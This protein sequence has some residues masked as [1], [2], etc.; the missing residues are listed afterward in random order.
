L[1]STRSKDPTTRNREDVEFPFGCREVFKAS[2]RNF[3]NGFPVV[4]TIVG[5]RW[6]FDL[7]AMLTQILLF[8]ALAGLAFGQTPEKLPSFDAADVHASPKSPNPNVQSLGGFARGGRYQF[9]N[10]TMVD[11]ISSAYGVEPE[12]VLGGPSWLETDRFDILAKAPTSVTPAT[13]KLMLRSLLAD[14]FKLAFHNEDKPMNGWVMTAAKPGPQLKQ[15]QGAGPTNCNGQP[16]DGPNS[17]IVCKNATMAVV[18]Q[19]V[20]QIEPAT[21]DTPVTD[22]TA[23]EGSF[24]FQLTWTNR[25]ALATAGKDAI[26]I[27]EAL[28]KQLGI[29]LELQKRAVATLVVDSVNRKPTDNLPG[30]EKLVPVVPTEFEVAEM[31]PSGPNTPVR[32]GLQPGGR[33]DLQGFTLKQLMLVSLGLVGPNNSGAGNAA[34]L[35]SGP[36]FL[37]SDHYDIVAKAPADVALSGTD[38]DAETLLAMLRTMLIDRFK[39][40]YHIEDQPINVYALTFQKRDSRLKQADPNSRSSCKR[41]VANNASGLPTATLTCQNTTLAQLAEKLPAM[42]PAYVDHP[43]VDVSGLDGGWDFALSWTP[44]AN[45]DGGQRGQAPAAV[46]ASDPNGGLSLFEGVERLGLKLEVRKH[47]Y[48]VLVIDHMETKPTEN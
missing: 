11:L 9:R 17:V 13:T 25:G 39:I 46:G 38:V 4:S 12:K 42:A 19:I 36:K 26:P 37:D 31:K 8:T 35:L 6:R 40:K 47:L 43:A 44:R 33:I 30:I 27:Q 45:F 22:L 48:P 3:P 32:G 41:T 10:A 7:K 28:E 34:D 29:K 23:L 1:E 15:S 5:L 18:G 2:F 14:R 21:F 16:G 20:R 24:D